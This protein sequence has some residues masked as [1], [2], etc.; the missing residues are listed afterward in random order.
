MAEFMLRPSP[1]PLKQIKALQFGV[2]SPEQI[3]SMSPLVAITDGGKNLPPGVSLPQTV[4]ELGQ[5]VFGG[6]SDPRMG[7]TDDM[8]DVGQFGFVELACPV[9]HV[10]FM[11]VILMLLRCVGYHSHKLL[12]K[13]SADDVAFK[14]L[15]GKRRLNH[16]VKLCEGVH[17]DSTNRPQPKY[18]RTGLTIWIDFSHHPSRNRRK[19]ESANLAGGENGE[20]ELEEDIRRDQDSGKRLLKASEVREILQDLDDDECRL[21]GFD[22]LYSKPSWL[23]YT[24]LPVPPLHVRPSIAMSSSQRCEDDITHQLSNVIK[25]NVSL[26]RAVVESA[27]QHVLDEGIS[28]LQWNVAVLVDNSLPYAARATQK[29][30]KPLKTLRQRLVGKEGRVRGNLMGKR[31][32]FT[33]RSVITADPNLSID[34]LGVPRSVAL[35][36]TVPERVTALNQEKLSALVRNGPI[37]YPGA[38]YVVKDG[39]RTDL[40]Y[41]AKELVLRLGDVVERHLMND[42]VVL[43]NRQPS[44]HKMSIM[45]HRVRVLPWSTFRLNLSVTTP[46]NADFD[47]DEMNMHVPQSLTARAEAES[48]MMVNKVIVSPQSNRP[49][50]GIVQDALLSSS[51]MTRRDVFVGKEMLFNILCWVESFNGDIPIPAVQMPVMNRPGERECWWT[52]KQLFSLVVPKEVNQENLRSNGHNKEEKIGDLSPF[53]T[54]VLIEE[55]EVL[56]GMIDKKTLGNSQGT[57]IHVVFN[58]C[59]PE[60][61]RIMFNQIQKVTNYWILQRSYTVGVGDTIA[62]NKVLDKVSEILSEASTGVAEIV[63]KAQH[64][65]LEAQPGRTLEDT[66]EDAVTI[67]LSNARDSAGKCAERSIPAQ[68]G[69]KGTVQAGSK[70]SLLNIAQIMTCVGQQNVDGKRIPWG[71]ER[72]TL[73]HFAKD[74]LGPESRGFV[75]NSYLKGLTP[76]EFFFH[77]MGGRVGLID[78]ACKTAETGYIQRR[79]VKGLEDVSVHYDGTVRNGRGEVIQFLYG[80]DGMDG[81]FIEAQTVDMLL[82]DQNKMKEMFKFEVESLDLGMYKG[83]LYLEANVIEQIRKSPETRRILEEEF[84]QLEADREELLKIAFARDPG[85]ARASDQNFQLPVNIA[86]MVLN[87]KKRWKMDM[88]RPSDLNPSEVVQQVKALCNKLVVVTGTDALSHEAQYNAT[89]LFLIHLRSA[90]SSKQCTRDYRFSTVAFNS[91]LKEIETRF[92]VSI[93]SPGEMCGVLAAQSIGEPATQMTLNTFHQAGVS[94]KNM[95]QGVP[96]LKEIINVSKNSRTPGLTVYL[97]PEVRFEEAQ[98]KRV[99]NLIEFANLRSFCETVEILYDPFPFDPEEDGAQFTQVKADVAW[100]NAYYESV[101]LQDNATQ[102]LTY[103]NLG[104]FV[105]RFVLSGAAVKFKQMTMKEISQKINNQFKDPSLFELICSSIEDVSPV[106]RI[107]LRR[108]VLA[109]RSNNGDLMVDESSDNEEEEML[110]KMS[111]VLLDEMILRGVKGIPKVSLRQE[112]QRKWTADKGF[113]NAQEWVL[114]T[115]GGDLRDVLIIDGVDHTRTYSNDI[116]QTIQVLGIEGTRRNIFNE[117]RTVLS[118]DGSYVNYRHLALLVDVMTS[119]GFIMAITR[120]GVNR[121]QSGALMR[122]SFEETVEILMEAAAFSELDPLSGVS[123]NI[124][125]G[126]LAPVGSGL[127]EIVLDEDVLVANALDNVVVE[128]EDLIYAQTSLYGGNNGEINPRTPDAA[129]PSYYMPN[130]PDYNGGAFSP[131][132]SSM[133][134]PGGGRSPVASNSPRNAS[135]PAYSPRSPAYSPSSPAYSP[136]SPAYSPSS[137]AYSPSSPAYSPSSPAYSPSSPAY[138]PSSPAYSPSSPAYSPSSPAYSPSSPAYSPSS[139]AYSPSSPAYSPS[140]PA[141]SPSSPAYSPSSPAYSPSSPAYSPSSPAYSPS[142]PAYSPSSP[143]YSPSSPAYSPS[144]PSNVGNLPPKRN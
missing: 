99:L 113:S 93:A 34:Q 33:A 27:P 53:D 130:S 129:S 121:T 82:Y 77:A 9:Y 100:V 131:E 97:S 102:Q 117:M 143:A 91:L 11:N 122:A 40:R 1:A 30:G 18:Q 26:Q 111:A 126:K 64:G 56:M 39:I 10:G 133:Y 125:M 29:S 107:R 24:V 13:P 16:L 45:G 5:P 38:R 74:D 90:L 120:H 17:N 80:E 83:S 47:G 22:P 71:F 89:L 101:L 7:T 132:S 136:S 54:W 86:R 52:G 114:D 60:V 61:A 21:L 55:G 69:F 59:G 94:N 62:D 109:R 96:R 106:L 51:L 58:E 44:L 66:F 65:E 127:C 67:K 2:M 137:P 37:V 25:A 108:N 144:N 119:K 124:M 6:L 116:L 4:N 72:R 79:L 36:M 84:T 139:P 31:V 81:M 87:A 63:K 46:Y 134:S 70:G 48:L 142:S 118:F 85:G 68:N 138:S 110:T 75:E 23:I 78:T 43:F 128:D 15:H 88:N 92:F 3:T 57:L 140:S 115:S 135:S 42:D 20:E 105:L 104:S 112:P 12:V 73:P 76:Q 41:S 49:V 35:H 28:L 141:Y 103:D 14:R 8:E 98:A 19:R 32:D 95:T 50:M 123:E